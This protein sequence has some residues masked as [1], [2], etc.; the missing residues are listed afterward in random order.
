MFNKF[1]KTNKSLSELDKFLSI[2]LNDTH[3][4][5]TIPEL[6]RL[7]IVEY[8]FNFKDA[9]DK[10]VKICSYTNHTLLQ[11]ALE[12]INLKFIKQLLPFHY[13]ILDKIDK[14]F[15]K[16]V[17]NKITNK[18]L[19]TVRIIQHNKKTKE[20][21]LNCGNLS[22]IAS[23]KV[24]GVAKLHT[25][26][27]KKQ[28][29]KLFNKLYP[30]KIINETNGI[31]Q[32]KWLLET[33]PDLANLISKTIGN[34]W[35]TDLSKLKE[36]LK[37][38]NNINFLNSLKKIK[39]NNKKKLLKYI[40]DTLNISINSNFMVD[41]QIKRIHEYKRQFLNILQVIDRYNKICSGETIGMIPKVYIFAGKAHPAY[42]VGIEIITLINDVAKVI[43]NDNRC[44]DLLRV[45]FIP[46]YNID[47]AKLIISASEVSEQIST[48]GKE[49]SGTGNMKMMINGALTIGTLDGA[50]IEIKEQVGNDNIYIFGLTAKQIEKEKSKYNI[51][52]FI[53]NNFN[54]NKIITDIKESKFGNV[55]RYQNLL[56]TFLEYNDK[57]MICK[58]FDDYINT[59]FLIDKDYKNK[60]NWYRKSLI[61]I[62]NAG[63][64]SSDR[65]IKGYINDI[66]KVKP[67]KENYE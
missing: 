48:A 52:E 38:K 56:T 25:E 4:C 22:V 13:I 6:I 19:E 1:K 46:N 62:A 53:K 63:F 57:F 67:I 23:N 61:N 50:N 41:S 7:L 17:K 59:Q 47:L 12:K 37:Y 36:L 54:L 16:L 49:A 35:I 20:K 21:F 15:C 42:K 44:K 34:N 43:N 64:F 5:L 3:P 33:N 30:K 10:T 14:D 39:T 32:R 65:T 60:N 51:K 9:Y 40:E 28:E 8:N 45:V 11:E 24:N 29:F 66:W 18:E 55:K 2:Q 31:S 26:L 27:L 58:D